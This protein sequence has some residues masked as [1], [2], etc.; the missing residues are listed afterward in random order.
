MPRKPNVDV[1]ERALAVPDDIW[2]DPRYRARLENPFGEA[3]API[4]LKDRSRRARW[5][6]AAIMEDKIWRAKRKGWDQ[7][8]EADVVDLEQ[9]GGYSK[10]PDGFITRGERGREVLMSIPKVV[11]EAIEKAK[12]AYNNRNMGDPGKS[13]AEIVEAA[14]QQRGDQAAEFLSRALV[15]VR[16][17]YERV[18]RSDE[19]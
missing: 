7:V 14:G 12:V 2:N 11:Y 8:R 17:T 9:I 18:Q 3:S 5:F 4:E 10:S 15:D 13:K 19:V 6:N 1:T 16:D